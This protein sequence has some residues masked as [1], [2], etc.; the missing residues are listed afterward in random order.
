MSF[1]VTTGTEKRDL[2][3]DVF[4]LGKNDAFNPPDPPIRCPTPQNA[5]ISEMPR[6]NPNPPANE[7]TG[8]PHREFSIWLGT[9]QRHRRCRGRDRATR[10]KVTSAAGIS[11][12]TRKWPQLFGDQWIRR[13]RRVVASAEGKRACSQPQ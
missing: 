6:E 2:S 12:A 7:A 1:L 3:S 4:L 13:G 9:S 8:E 11:P 5:S 10:A